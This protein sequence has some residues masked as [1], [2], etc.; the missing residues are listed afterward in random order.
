MGAGP[1]AEA[2]GRDRKRGGG[3]GSGPGAGP[4]MALRA[5]SRL[6]G[7]L[8]WVLRA[9]AGAW[10]ARGAAGSGLDELRAEPDRFGGLWVRLAARP[11][12]DPAAFRSRLQGKWGRGRT[13]LSARPGQARRQVSAPARRLA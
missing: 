9:R 6:P 7:A 13:G 2:Q 8:G 10:Q 11:C 1:E 4:A 12:V 5:V 3:T